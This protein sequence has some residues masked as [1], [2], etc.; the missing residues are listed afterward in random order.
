MIKTMNLDYT[1]DCQKCGGRLMTDGEMT[2]TVEC[3]YPEDCP[4]K[5]EFK[6]I[7]KQRADN[8]QVEK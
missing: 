8:K 3:A 7:L 4:V 1:S 6:R 5:T 2:Y